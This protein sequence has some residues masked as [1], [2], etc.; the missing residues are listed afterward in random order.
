MP[1]CYQINNNAQVIPNRSAIR[2]DLGL[3][4]DGFVY[5]SFCTRYKFDPIMFNTWMKILKKV[6]N[7]VLWILGGNR[8]AERNL[9]REAEAS[10]VKSDRLVFAPKIPRDNHLSR[11]RLADLALDTRIVNGAI[12]TSDAL[13]SGVPVITLQGR[14]FASRMSSSILNAAGLLNLV[15]HSLE[16]YEA[17]AI[18]LADPSSELLATRQKLVRNRLSIP[19]FDTARFVRNLEYA[20]VKM[21]EIYDS[22]QSPRLIRVGEVREDTKLL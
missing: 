17:L 18:R 15:T 20:F 7:S 1:D 6:P 16:D 3:P 19:L 9:V 13:W 2:T 12:T 10:G 11:L 5:C 8:T 21:R 22:G 14:H 4:N